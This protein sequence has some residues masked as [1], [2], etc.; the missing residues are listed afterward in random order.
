MKTAISIPDKVFDAAEKL[1]E[2]LEISR[3]QLYTQA[4]GALIENYRY[5]GVTEKL[6]AV[7]SADQIDSG[8]ESGLQKIQAVS[9]DSEK[10]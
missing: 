3:S 9:I 7:Y 10:W 8:L 1:A 2:H 4:V 5:S 6:D